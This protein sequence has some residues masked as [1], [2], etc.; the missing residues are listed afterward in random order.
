MHKISFPAV[1]A[2]LVGLVPSAYMSADVLVVQNI[3]SREGYRYVL[4]RCVGSILYR[5][6]AP[7]DAY[8]GDTSFSEYSSEAF[9]F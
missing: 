2:R 6:G 9:S 7:Q 1:R 3:P 8:P 5:H 4:V